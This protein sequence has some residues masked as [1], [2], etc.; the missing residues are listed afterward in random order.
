MGELV[1]ISGKDPT[2]YAG[3]AES[4]M[5]GQVMLA[6][7]AGYEPHLF[8][9]GDRTETFESE[10]GTVHRVRTPLRL[11]VA[12]ASAA[13]RPWLTPAVVRFLAGR[14]GP[15]VIQAHAGWARLAADAAATLTARGVVTRTFA[16]YY[17]SVEHE[18][19]A[20]YYG[21]GLVQAS[22]RRRLGYGFMLALVRATA[23]PNE[24]SGYRRADR[25]A[26]N[27]ENVRRLLA[28]AYGERP[29]ERISYCA[30]A[31]LRPDAAFVRRPALNG[32]RASGPPLVVSVSRHSPR[33]GLD[34]L[35]RAVAELRDRGVPFRAT[36]V[37]GGHLLNPH[38]RLASELGLGAQVSFPGIVPDPVP[39][40]RECEVFCLPSTA[41]DSGSMSVLEALQLGAPIVASAVDGLPEDLTH[42]RNALLA[43][44][45]SVS[46][47]ARQLARALSDDRLRERLSLAGRATYEAR[48]TAGR[49]G[50]E[51]AR[52][53]VELGLQP[54]IQ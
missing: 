42:D 25:V 10:L 45:G 3:G 36:L 28:D 9:L 17:S 5:V 29:V 26:V 27:Y 16:V 30:P 34:V 15:H 54:S 35:I 19:G 50:A 20:K 23:V 41:E 51:L 21:A 52:V 1:M 53:Y 18:Q 2:R 4:Y 49:A 24:R 38:R 39:Y 46:D 37:G 22:V 44:P 12:Y 13:H 31:A 7:R 48:F 6:R 11:R 14:R 33:K 32:D 43:E 40:L 47:L 8:V